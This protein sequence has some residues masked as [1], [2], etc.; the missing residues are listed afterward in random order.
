MRGRKRRV[1]IAI[2]RMDH[3]WYLETVEVVES[4]QG[5]FTK[6]RSKVIQALRRAKQDVAFVADYSI[7]PLDEET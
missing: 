5:M 2:G 7:L 4:R 3:T 1:E 6:A